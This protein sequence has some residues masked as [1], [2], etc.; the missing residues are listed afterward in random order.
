[1]LTKKID[2]PMETVLEKVKAW[3]D[4][5]QVQ[6]I[7][8]YLEDKD[9]T[10]IIRFDEEGADGLEEFFS[11]LSRLKAQVLVVNLTRLTRDDWQAK[12]EESRDGEEL[13]VIKKCEAKVGHIA[14][15]RFR[16]LVESPTMILK[17]DISADWFPLIYGET[18]EGD[19]RGDHDAEVEEIARQVAQDPSFHR[20]KNREQREHVTKKILASNRGAKG[21]G[22]ERIVNQTSAIYET[23]LKP[24]L[25]ATL[26]EQITTLRKKGLKLEKIATRVGLSVQEVKSLVRRR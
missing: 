6:L 4:Q 21:L 3:C 26:L 18:H 22:L 5:K 23:E 7:Q 13:D 9:T 2:I 14:A 10:P 12:I 16:G 11:A 8:G 17:H 19:K 15:L 20:A 1:M 25:E 24:Q